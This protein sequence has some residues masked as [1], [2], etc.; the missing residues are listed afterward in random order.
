MVETAVG[1]TLEGEALEQKAKKM[2]TYISFAAGMAGL[3]FGLDIGVIAG[4]LP[5]IT[6]HF[7]LDSRTQEWVVS[8]MMLGAAI[9]SV[10]T[11]WISSRLGRKKSLLTGAGLF[12]I[13]CFGSALTP[14]VEFLICSRIILGFS[15]GVASYTAPLYLSEMSEKETRGRLISMYQLMINFGIVLAF[16]SDTALSYSG[17][18]R[19]ML[20]VISLPAFVLVF[21]V[22]GLP[23]SPRWLAS[24]GRFSDA[25]EVLKSLRGNLGKAAEELDEIRS[26]LTV[27]Q[28]GWA[29][30]RENKNV[31]RAV[32]LGML[33]QAMQQFTGMNIIMYYAPKIFSLAGFSSTTDQMIATVIDG[34]T[35]VVMTYVAMQFID[36]IGRKPALKIGFFI[37][38]VGTIVLGACLYMVDH[39]V[40]AAWISYLSV[41][42]TVL[43]IA[44][45]AMSAAPVI[46]ILCSEIQPLKS[47][48]FGIAC[49]TTTN[50]VSN[51]IIGA[52][53]LTL[54]DS[55]GSAST[56]WLYGALNILFIFLTIYVIPETKNVTLEKIEKNLME[57]KPLRNIGC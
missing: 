32:W 23:D 10:A 11:A 48:D 49:S 21:A 5:F 56:F 19:M 12:I 43:C 1:K 34:M 42:M 17:D 46:W 22:F 29:L 50:W 31:R 8:A 15:I 30:F 16:L 24:K 45:Y 39:G 33:L 18:W 47:R 25:K 28:E 4:A 53:F 3:L 13:G 14:N 55:I 38:A 44:G 26:S 2:K 6:T 7:D 27:K 40:T 9:G 37:M 20:G 57:G 35:F 36:R 51:M 54:L 52:T 41:A